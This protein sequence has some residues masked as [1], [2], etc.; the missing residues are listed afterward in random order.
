[1]TLLFVVSV[2]VGSRE[3]IGLLV[4]RAVLCSCCGSVSAN[5]IVESANYDGGGVVGVGRTSARVALVRYRLARSAADSWRADIG[6][7]VAL[8]RA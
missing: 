7:S 8:V 2:S 1:M 6:V 5:F 3:P 4:A